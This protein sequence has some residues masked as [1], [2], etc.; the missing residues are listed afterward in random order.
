MKVLRKILLGLLCLLLILPVVAVVALQL[1]GVQNRICKTISKN[2]SENI[3]GSIDFGEVYY[4]LFDR[5]IIKDAVLKDDAQD[6]VAY[7]GKL[8]LNVRLLKAITGHVTVSKFELSDALLNL[9]VDEGGTLNLAKIFPQKEKVRDTTSKGILSYFDNVL[10]DVRNIK[11]NDMD[12]N[13]VNRSQVEKPHPDRKQNPN[14]D[15]TPGK[16]TI[17]WK[18]L[19]VSGLDLDI[20]DIKYNLRK[21]SL[22]LNV[23]GI[24]LEESRGYKLDEMKFKAALDSEGIHLEKF[25][26][27][28]NYSDLK[29]DYANVLF[30]DIG[31]FF[32]YGLIITGFIIFICI[33]CYTINDYHDY[34][35]KKLDEKGNLLVSKK[36][37]QKAIIFDIIFVLIAV[38]YIVVR[39]VFG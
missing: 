3:N 5:I 17:D 18:D 28:D 23:N 21:Q 26:Y 1:P 20:S 8:S 36:K 30:D 35:N 24:S 22:S 29:M 15:L 6:T 33:L 16:N 7:L 38:A 11:V 37:V 27:A 9:E 31:D 25:R 12:L 34:K 13:L 39:I 19:H 2:I 14:R 4:E 32:Q 10:V